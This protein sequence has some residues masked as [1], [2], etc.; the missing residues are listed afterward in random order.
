MQT[1]AIIG[2]SGVGKTTLVSSIKDSLSFRHLE[3]SQLLKNEFA[4]KSIGSPSSEDLR[5]GDI[6][7]NQAILLRSFRRD[8]DGYDGLV[9]F[10]GHI[11]IDGRDGVVE[12]PEDVFR[13][14]GV[15][16][17]VFVQAAA[18]DIARRRS[19]DTQRT[20]PERGITEIAEQQWRALRLVAGYALSMKTPL[21][22]IA[23]SDRTSLVEFMS[24]KSGSTAA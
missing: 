5:Q 16:K 18:D 11:L 13:K 4:Y 10:D 22:V 2:I 1:A 7:G 15:R 9:V 17:F 23:P 3:A 24:T 6:L 19:S 14:L 21:L 20:R 8:T 12:I